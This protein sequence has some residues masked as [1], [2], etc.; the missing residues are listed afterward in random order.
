M[1]SKTPLLM[2]TALVCGLGA[3]FGTWKLVS[4]AQNAPAEDEKVKVL[5]PVAEVAPYYMFQ[6]A[7]RFTEMEWPKSRL[8]E[9]LSETITSFDQIKN[10]TSRH[11]KLRPNEPMYKNDICENM[12]HDVTERLKNGEVAHAVQVTA[13]RAGGGFI[14]V[15]DRVDISATVL[16]GNGE[17]SIK[18]LYLLEDIEVLA[19]DNR[20]Q[21]EANSMATPPTRFLL[22]LTRPQALTLKYF[23]DT[24]K[25]DFDKRKL[26][27]Q[28]RV[29]ESFY[30]NGNKKP[31]ATPG[32]QEDVPDATVTVNLE[33]RRLP[34]PTDETASRVVPGKKP[35]TVAA[36]TGDL[37][38]DIIKM[39]QHS[40]TIND[41]GTPR[42]QKTNEK[43][44]ELEKVKKDAGKTNEE[45]KKDPNEQ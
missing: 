3:A 14:N 13:E 5:V 9:D 1:Q 11:Y 19:V 31:S 30:F 8:R 26:G 42:I 43:Y 16:P 10:K 35:E 12:E 32:Y 34:D 4:G 22:R 15:G 28:S 45:G 21:K 38:E 33:E 17:T 36:G 29:G 25:I 44:R 6:D 2:V 39:K 18:T 40:V 24:A 20:S 27:D 7:Q 37:W 41:S 23:Q